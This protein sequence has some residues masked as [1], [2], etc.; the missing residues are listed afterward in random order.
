MPSKVSDAEFIAAWYSN[1][2]R[3]VN[4]ARALGMT[5]RGVMARRAAVELKH[6]V[7]LETGGGYHRTYSTRRDPIAERIDI[8]IQDAVCIAFSDAH[9]WPGEPPPIWQAMLRLSAKLKPDH[10]F[11]V[12]DS[13]DGATVSRHP[14]DPQ[15][16]LPS[17][18]AE[19]DAARTRKDEL[20]RTSPDAPC[21]YTPGNHCL[22]LDKRLAETA[23]DASKL[24]RV[25]DY[26]PDWTPAHTIVVNGNVLVMHNYRG[27]IHHTWNDTLLAG[28][29]TITGHSH[30]GFA[31]P[32][33]DAN[34]RIRFGVDCGTSQNVRGEQFKYLQGRPRPTWSSSFA[35][36]TWRNGVLLDPEFCR[37]RPEL[38]ACTFRGEVV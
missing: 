26:F 29:T 8:K 11:D 17:F 7:K 25:V 16:E 5:D 27:G 3:P 15:A 22:R 23:G 37:Y 10:F 20:R 18:T 2:A 6:N 36:L 31:R 32:I 21:W 14:H 28:M 1:G 24:L 19:L 33:A 30:Q 12:G 9:I 38:D 35:V 4:V 13:V 34:D